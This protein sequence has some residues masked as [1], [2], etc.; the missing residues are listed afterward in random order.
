MLRWLI[1]YIEIPVVPTH[2]RKSTKSEHATTPCDKVATTPQVIHSQVKTLKPN[3]SPL[4]ERK[5]EKSTGTS[6]VTTLCD[7]IPIVTEHA[8]QVTY[9]QVKTLKPNKFTMERP[10]KY[11]G[12]SSVT[13]PCD[14]IPFESEN[15]TQV[16]NRQ[17]KTLKPNKS[18]LEEEYS[19]ICKK[20]TSTADVTTPSDRM[21]PAMRNTTTTPEKKFLKVDEMPEKGEKTTVNTCDTTPCVPH[22]KKSL[23]E[24]EEPTEKSVEIMA[25]I[26]EILTNVDKTAT[27]NGRKKFANLPPRNPSSN[28]SA[29]KSKSKPKFN[30]NKSKS[31]SNPP[32]KPKFPA[33]TCHHHHHCN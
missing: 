1:E 33:T 30:P 22:V 24:S 4:D 28:A 2:Q 27:T 29:R 21:S 20:S 17:V 26:E 18:T 15:A 9:R 25:I 10:E 31:K 12:M 11:T 19:L 23:M 8:T 7:R 32:K 16:T 6:S 14:K 3:K 5:E 13:T